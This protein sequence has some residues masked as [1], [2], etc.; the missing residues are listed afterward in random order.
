MAM[1]YSHYNTDIDRKRTEL[2]YDEVDPT[3]GMTQ[4]D[5]LAFIHGDDARKWPEQERRKLQ[6]V[7]KYT[8]S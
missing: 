8:T 7:Q 2:D 4:W 3:T 1:H 5:K 6:E